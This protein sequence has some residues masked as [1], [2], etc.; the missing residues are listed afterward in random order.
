MQRRV[1]QVGRGVL[2]VRRVDLCRG[3]TEHTENHH[4]PLPSLARSD[5]HGVYRR[6]RD[7][8]LSSAIC[9]RCTVR[10]GRTS[11]NKAVLFQR[12]DLLDEVSVIHRLPGFQGGERTR[13]Q[14]GLD[15]VGR[16]GHG[17]RVEVG[18]KG[19]SVSTPKGS[20]HVLP[21]SELIS[22]AVERCK[23]STC[24]LVKTVLR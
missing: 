11:Y 4:S 12:A 10:R 17:E 15:R 5:A 1:E 2:S 24:A 9:P 19:G 21:G 7:A 8:T 6:W 13:E 22:R 14:R 23:E 20:V 3:I 16:R 18:S